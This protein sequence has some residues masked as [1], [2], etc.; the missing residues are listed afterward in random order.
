MPTT[1][2]PK[3]VLPETLDKA[4]RRYRLRNPSMNNVAIAQ[5]LTIS[6][7]YNDYPCCFFRGGNLVAVRMKQDEIAIFHVFESV[8]A[9][10]DDIGIRIID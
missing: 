3:F 4:T 7:G 8:Q 2:A 10:M 6:N 9:R 5:H 1:T